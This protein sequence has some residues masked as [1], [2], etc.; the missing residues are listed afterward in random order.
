M[1]ITMQVNIHEAK[2]QLSRLLEMVEQG[3]TVVIARH[4]KPVAKLVLVQRGLP[5]GIAVDEA[6]VPAGDDWWKPMTDEES[7]NWV[8]GL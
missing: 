5:L 4:G 1:S 8:S 7:D 6:L 3:E 2:T